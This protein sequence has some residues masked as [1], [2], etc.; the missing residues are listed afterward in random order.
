MAPTKFI[1]FS[2]NEDDNGSDGDD[3]DDYGLLTT[4]TSQTEI[5]LDHAN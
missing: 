2:H 5:A 4:V 3:D 1:S